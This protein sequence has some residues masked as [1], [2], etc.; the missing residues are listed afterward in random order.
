MSYLAPAG[1]YMG[2]ADVVGGYSIGLARANGDARLGEEI[3]R[4][5]GAAE[6]WPI[7]S[8]RAAMTVLLRAMAAASRD[9]ARN[10]VLIPAYT[11]YSVPASIERA[12]LVPRVCDVDPETLGMDIAALERSDF[13]RVLAIVTANLYGIP[14]DLTAIER[15]ARARG[16]YLL[17]DAAQALGARFDGRAVGTFGDAGLYSFDK[18]KVICTIQGGVMVTRESRG[19]LADA[20]RAEA[21][22]LP[23]PSPAE[24]LM[25]G[26][27]LPVYVFGLRP[28]MY[29]LIR[30]LP[31][32]GLGRT[33]YEPRYPIAR[34]GRLQAGVARRLLPRVG[35]LNTVRR[36]NAARLRE[37]L[38]DLA[39]VVLPTI[40]AR[41][42]SI[43][44]RFPLRV[45]DAA[46]RARLLGALDRAGI[47]AT[48]SYPC[49]LPD[50]P[51][52]AA[53]LGSPPA[54][55]GARMIAA[56]IVTLPT[57]GYCPADL[58]DRVRRIAEVAL[59]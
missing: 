11:C 55:P 39:G 49:A 45:V 7:A 52:V 53:R 24:V 20:L 25:N 5:T 8:G 28:A 43:F 30:R 31:F 51:E 35:Q 26:I 14:N 33:E 56:Q 58:G 16:V 41:A 4:A 54:V 27:K 47:G 48:G 22:A 42:E 10:E 9:P 3:A 18:G 37:R 38:A 23:A 21:R 19:A 13:G 2:L 40:P 57:H 29:G 32:L 34:L 36:E 1:T 50:V 6:A 15:I 17:D 59:R 44:T 12:G 46:A